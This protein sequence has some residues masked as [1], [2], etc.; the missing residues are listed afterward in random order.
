MKIVVLVKPG[1]SK[2]KVEKTGE[3][4][5]MVWVH[6]PPVENKANLAVIKQLSKHLSVPRS[7]ISIFK[8]SKGKRKIF[9]IN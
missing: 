5:Y 7:A 8:G 1:S 4:Q 3:N 9:D 6:Q 2:E